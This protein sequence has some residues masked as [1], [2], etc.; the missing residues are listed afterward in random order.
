YT[1]TGGGA[2]RQAIGTLENMIKSRSFTA[3]DIDGSGR[4]ALVVG[5]RALGSAGLDRTCLFIYRFNDSTH[6]WERET[7]DTSGS[8]GFHCVAIA[9]V[10]G[11]GQSE[12]IASDDG[13]GLIKLYKRRG[14]RWQKQ[15]IHDAQGPILC[16]SI[17][18]IE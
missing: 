6:G 14:R 16:N 9:D 3:G 17:H 4:N 8:L 12:I 11:D 5:T 15:T 10:D 13:C 1:L 7:L 18:L 2:A